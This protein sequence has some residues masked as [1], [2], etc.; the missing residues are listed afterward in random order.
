MADRKR[1]VETWVDE[2]LAPLREKG[3][4]DTPQPLKERRFP[5]DITHLANRDLGKLQSYMRAMIGYYIH[6]EKLSAIAAY[7]AERQYRH[8]H[9]KW[10]FKKDPGDRSMN[11]ESIDALVHEIKEVQE[12]DGM[13]EVLKA[14]HMEWSGKVEEYRGYIETISREQSRRADELQYG[15]E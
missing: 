2:T 14:Q 13:W 3:V 10:F 11:K 4:I 12:W 5:V 7:H 9:R 1:Q 15:V 8:A 6:Q